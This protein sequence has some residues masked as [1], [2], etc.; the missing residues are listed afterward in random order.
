[1]RFERQVPLEVNYKGHRIGNYRL[2]LLVED[3]VIVELKAVKELLPVHKAQV[4]CYLRITGVKRGLLLNFNV[5]VLRFG[6]DRVS[7]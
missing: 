2:D 1:M 7:L 4:L 3:R 6:I 5:E